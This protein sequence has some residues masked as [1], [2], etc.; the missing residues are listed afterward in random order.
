MISSKNIRFHAPSN[1]YIIPKNSVIDQNVMI[2][3][4]AIIGPGVHF[5]KNVKV[6]G[7]AKIGK[8]C[9]IEGNLKAEKI[10][11]GSYSKIKGDISAASDVSLFQ[12]VFVRSI[13][14]GENITIMPN[15]AVGYANGKTLSVIGKAEINKIG[16]ITKVTVRAEFINEADFGNEIEDENEIVNANGILAADEIV[17]V[18]ENKIIDNTT[19]DKIDITDEFENKKN[20]VEK[21]EPINP[22]FIEN[23]DN[24]NA[25]LDSKTT[26]VFQVENSN[27]NIK[28]N[29]EIKFDTEDK[30][31]FENKFDIENKSDFENK[32]DNDN[33]SVFSSTGTDTEIIDTMDEDSPQSFSESF[34]RSKSYSIDISADEAEEV[35][36]IKSE[37]SGNGDFDEPKST[38]NLKTIETPFGTIVI[39]EQ[40][41][42]NRSF[43]PETTQKDADEQFASI[44]HISREEQQ[45]DYEAEM[46]SLKSSSPLTSDPSLTPVS[47]STSPSTSSSSLP[48]STKSSSS[49]SKQTESEKPRWPVFDPQDRTRLGNSKIR[50]EVVK[51]ETVITD[52]VENEAIEDDSVKNRSPFK[53]L[54]K[55]KETSA[56]SKQV[57]NI[58]KANEKIIFEEIE[59]QNIDFEESE[60]GKSEKFGSANRSMN[61]EQRESPVQKRIQERFKEQA[62]IEKQE[63]DRQAQFEMEHSKM[64]YENRHP[65]A[66]QKKKEYPPYL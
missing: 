44:T 24:N 18:D 63:R 52:S 19:D 31:N 38:E 25:N 56:L 1:T 39:D 55:I 58:Q 43:K 3:G 60:T 62:Q 11:V 37:T 2:K 33:K 35:E 5:W 51:S 23:K 20:G 36:I 50:Y 40:D 4:N 8:G 28:S 17:T 22:T 41:G 53:D 27:N 9:I 49:G 26:P 29:F 13:E 66:P 45:A 65:A 14:S 7:V 32:F 46:K 15:C 21:S 61:Q 6:D 10:I 42:L 59:A 16:C 47:P 57:K 64:W 30:S 54:F 12:S 48:E 34:V